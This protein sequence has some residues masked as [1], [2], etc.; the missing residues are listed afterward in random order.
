MPD[1]PADLRGDRRRQVERKLAAYFRD[2]YGVIN[3]ATAGSIGATDAYIEWRVRTGD[4]AVRHRRVYLLDSWPHSPE[5]EVAA[6]L[7]AVSAVAT[8]G[9]RAGAGRRPSTPMAV[10]SHATAGWLLGLVERP[11]RQVHIT[12][13]SPWRHHLAGVVAHTSG[14]PW[15]VVRV[16]GLPCADATRTI[17]DVAPFLSD[18][19]LAGVVDRALAAQLTAVPRL[20]GALDGELAGSRGATALRRHLRDRGFVGAPAP[21]VLEACMH[22]LLRRFGLPEP[23]VQLWVDGDGRRYRLDF[24]YPHLKLAIEVKGYVWHW[25][26]EKMA[27]DDRRQNGLIS[28]G[29]TFLSFDWKAVVHRPAEVAATIAATLRLLADRLASPAPLPAPGPARP[30]S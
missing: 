24:A 5:Q 16:R 9:R 29:W 4:W 7:A 19:A 17:V 26:P 8:G 12:V 25:S 15:Q 28:G 6:A 22:R 20:V 14:R 27:E 1:L 11:P 23:E 13:P 30:A 3:R 18:A 21:S 2:H 10:A